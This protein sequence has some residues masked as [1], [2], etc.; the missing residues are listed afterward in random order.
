MKQFLAALVLLAAA[1]GASAAPL[2]TEEALAERVLG[3]PDAP[4]TII[5]YSSLGCPHC[6]AFH[7]E[8]LPVIQ[9]RYIDTGKVRLIF[10]DFPFGVPALAAAMLARCAPQERYFAF[11]EVLFKSQPSW[12]PAEDPLAALIQVA[13]M[14][15][16][17]KADFDACIGN[18][19]L[20][21]AIQQR[22]NRASE[23]MDVN[24]TPT[25]FINGD[26]IE[27]ARPFE[28]FEEVIEKHLN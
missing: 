14:G 15:G 28:D 17:S 6:A 11:I 7:R 24:S 27:G 22:K 13:R 26:K 18:Q 1:G 25:F 16:L 4:V 23:D 10:N 8:T 9:E 20:L 12:A 3:S 19:E 2:S 5:E 21:E